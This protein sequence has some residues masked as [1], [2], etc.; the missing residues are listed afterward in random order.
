MI[1]PVKRAEA[2]TLVCVWN[3]GNGRLLQT[4][5]KSSGSGQLGY[6]RLVSYFCD[7]LIARRHHNGREAVAGSTVKRWAQPIARAKQTKLEPKVDTC[8]MLF[9][10]LS[11][12]L[13]LKSVAFTVIRVCAFYIIPTPPNFFSNLRCHINIYSVYREQCLKFTVLYSVTLLLLTSAL[14]LIHYGNLSP[15]SVKTP[16]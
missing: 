13:Q 9:T 1:S 8:F 16:P 10:K 5:D 7:M 15:M 3:I 12:V 6:R 4:A 14:R 2:L 11:H